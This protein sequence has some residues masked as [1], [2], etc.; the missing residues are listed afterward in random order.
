MRRDEN[1]SPR[2]KWFYVV[3]TLIAASIVV[4]AVEHCSKAARDTSKLSKGSL[5]VNVNQATVAELQTL[6]GVGPARAQLIVQHRPYNTV[7]DLAQKRV[8]PRSIVD[9]D[10]MFLK[11]SGKNERVKRH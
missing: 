10:K 11:T 8:L 6:P 4:S 9:Q 2:F 5:V 7:D 1:P 3:A